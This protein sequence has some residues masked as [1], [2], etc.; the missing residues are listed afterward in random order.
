MAPSVAPGISNQISKSLG[1]T[2]SETSKTRPAAIFGCLD[3]C[4]HVFH[5][6]ASSERHSVSSWILLD[7]LFP[8][9]ALICSANFT[10][11]SWQHQLTSHVWSPKTSGLASF[12][13]SFSMD[14][15]IIRSGFDICFAMVRMGISSWTHHRTW[16][17][18]VRLCVPGSCGWEII[19]VQLSALHHTLLTEQFT[20]H[21]IFRSCKSS[22][23]F[24]VSHSHLDSQ[25]SPQKTKTKTT[26]PT[27]PP[28]SPAEP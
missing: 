27:L 2:S 28:F 25:S 26:H 7:V 9:H 21:T 11:A 23:T 20:L 16:S 4:L 5:T 24:T 13:A 1:P 8:Q 12:L 18:C 22:F 14:S 17:G 3:L 19:K 6:G 10:N 15:A